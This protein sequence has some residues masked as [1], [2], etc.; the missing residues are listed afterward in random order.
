MRPAWKAASSL[1][2]G[3]EH[4]VDVFVHGDSVVWVR[5]EAVIDTEEEGDHIGPL[6]L[7]LLFEVAWQIEHT[8]AFW[9]R[10]NKKGLVLFSRERALRSRL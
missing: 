3:I 2:G 4:A 10:Q 5:S 7:A 9:H 8:L 6:I 1:V